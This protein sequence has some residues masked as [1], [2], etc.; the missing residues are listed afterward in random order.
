MSL[1]PNLVLN[2]QDYQKVDEFRQS[3]DTAILTILFTDIVGFTDLTDTYGDVVSNQ[4]RHIHDKLFTRLIQETKSAQIIKQIGDSF[5]TV[6]AE[7]TTAVKVALEFQKQ[8][9][10]NKQKLRHEK[11]VLKVRI[12]IHLG[13]VTFENSFGEDIFGYQVNKASRIMSIARGE[14][15]LITDSVK[16]NLLTWIRSQKKKTI[17]LKSYGRL[18]LKGIKEKTA[19]SQVYYKNKKLRK[20][21]AVKQR[22]RK[23]LIGL[24]LGCS[25][26]L[27]SYNMITQGYN[28]VIIGMIYDDEKYISYE[29]E[30]IN[31]NRKD[32]INIIELSDSLAEMINHTLYNNLLNEFIGVE[33]QIL[34]NADLENIYS[35]SLE[36][37]IK[38]Y[39]DAS[40]KYF[41]LSSF[42]NEL[43]K[44]VKAD[45]ILYWVTSDFNNNYHIYKIYYEAG[46]LLFTD[47]NSFIERNNLNEE[48]NKLQSRDI[49]MLTRDRGFNLIEY[50]TT[51]YN[52]EIVGRANWLGKGYIDEIFDDK[53]KIKLLSPYNIKKGMGLRVKKV[54]ALNNANERKRYIQFL[55]Y[56]IIYLNSVINLEPIYPL[57]NKWEPILRNY[58]N[59]LD[60]YNEEEYIDIGNQFLMHADCGN[61]IL[62]IEEVIDD[63]AIATLRYKEYP[64]IT[65]EKEDK[66]DY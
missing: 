36:D 55:N 16:D 56:N 52:Q 51:L 34:N 53:Y 35:I 40:D 19:V 54:F 45:L 49:L 27:F 66:V 1:K 31:R 60:D 41:G 17:N 2:S 32:T 38:K 42:V 50:I 62:N 57:P 43:L 61:I 46:R 25:L 23:R 33:M 37:S 4:I 6:F 59:Q 9:D 39:Y 29:N 30:L 58:K 22:N 18:K 13:Q 14:Q 63:Y 64:W 12:G 24:I 8:L 65:I 20:P 10:D 3:C 11:Y 47:S 26:M 21:S 5:L 44:I 28:K 15:V 48:I 7:P